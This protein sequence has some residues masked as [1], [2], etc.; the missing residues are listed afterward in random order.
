MPELSEVEVK[1]KTDADSKGID[2]AESKIMGFSKR[3]VDAF[4]KVA[5]GIAGLAVGVGAAAFSTIGDFTA[6]EDAL[7]RLKQGLTNVTGDSDKASAAMQRLGDQAGNLQKTTRFA[8]EQIASGQ[9]MLTTFKLSEDSISTLTPKML[10]MAEAMRKSTGQAPDLEQLGIMFGKVM[11]NAEGGVEGLASGLKK[12]GVIMTEEQAAVFKFGTETERAA[13]LAKIMD[14]NFAGFATAG[15][16]TFS[17]KMDIMNN[18]IGE[19]KESIGGMLVNALMPLVSWVSANAIPAFQAFT[20]FLSEH[21]AVAMALGI[22]IGTVVVGAFVALGIAATTAAVG[23][24]AASWPILAVVAAIGIAAA[25]LYLAWNSN[26]LGIRNT[27]QAVAGFITGVIFPQI[28]AGINFVRSVLPGL[29]ATWNTIWGGIRDTT[30]SVTNSIIN[31][32]KNM[33]NSVIGAINTMIRGA[34]SVGS[35][36]GL[37]KIGEIPGFANGVQNFRGGLAVVGE[38]GPELV[39]LPKGSDVIPN[40]QMAG[41]GL[42]QINYNYNQ[43]DFESS[44]RELAWDL[45]NQ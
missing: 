5:L 15:G 7:A 3:S 21:Q 11:G 41:G 10:D 30:I 16:A 22:I 33:V 26:F 24:I 35:K 14:D 37:G 45:R 28:M 27:T 13:M 8:D 39:N 4:N 17:G 9:A 1:I 34:N 40:G 19:I 44:M 36:V 12:M 43:I 20:Q 25:V 38:R 29:Q 6:Q 23:V 18:Q 31:T 42:T 32:V 2:E